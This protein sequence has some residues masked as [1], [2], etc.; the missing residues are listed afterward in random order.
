[1]SVRTLLNNQDKQIWSVEPD[2]SV[3]EAIRLMADRDTGAVL[4]MQ[5]SALVGIFTERDYARK[6]ILHGKLSKD[7]KVRDV[8][9][10]SLITVTPQ[11]T[12][13][14]CI[15]LMTKHH[16]R[17]LPVVASGTVVGLISVRDVMRSIVGDQ[18]EAIKRL[19]SFAMGEESDLI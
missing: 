6:V 11:H 5:E 10:S 1:M 16:I 7:L 12:I 2:A 17:H 3:Y 4:V 19:E 13:S 8:M 14:E 18:D 15:S 9:T